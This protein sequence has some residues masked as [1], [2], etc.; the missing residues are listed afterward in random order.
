MSTYSIP[1]SFRRHI[2]TAAWHTADFDPVWFNSRGTYPDENGRMPN[3]HRETDVLAHVDFKPMHDAVALSSAM[4][5]K[6]DNQ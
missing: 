3:I 1:R 5:L 6:L 4:I 2:T